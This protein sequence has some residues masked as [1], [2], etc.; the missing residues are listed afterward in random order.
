MLRGRKPSLGV[1]NERPI[2][3]GRRN[4]WKRRELNDGFD[5]NNENKTN[6]DNN[7]NN[8]GEQ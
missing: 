1:E 4:G 6:N 3:H 7:S 5:N 2:V 8:D